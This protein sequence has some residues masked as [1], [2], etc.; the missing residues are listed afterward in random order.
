MSGYIEGFAIS[1]VCLIAYLCC[2]AII[3]AKKPQGKCPPYDKDEIESLRRARGE[4]PRETF[5]Q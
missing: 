3:E 2:M 4:L 5:E 1:F